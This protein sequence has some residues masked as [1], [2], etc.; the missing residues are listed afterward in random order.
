MPASNRD[1]YLSRLRRQ[2]R[3]LVSIADQVSR[4]PNIDPLVFF[5]QTLQTLLKALGSGSAGLHL[6]DDDN[7]RMHLIDQIGTQP[8]ASWKILQLNDANPVS[9]AMRLASP[10]RGD[11]AG[12]GGVLSVPIIGVQLPLGTLSVALPWLPDDELPDW[13]AFLL[14]AGYL[15]GIA[16]EHSGLINELLHNFEQ[17]MDLRRREAERLQS[18][19]NENKY[20][21]SA[22][23]DLYN[24]VITDPLTGLCNRRHIMELLDQ[25]IGRSERS[26]Q[27]FCLGMADLDHFKSINDRFGHQAGDKA[28]ALLAKWL[29][30]NTRQIDTV[31]RYGGEEF[32]LLLPNCSLDAGCVVAD[33]LRLMVEANSQMLELFAACGGFRMSVGVAQYQTGMN[34]QQLTRLAD[35]ALYQA[36]ANGRN[37]VVAAKLAF[38]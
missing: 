10:Q 18:L 14:G 11:I 9:Q 20:L 12:I 8:L 31:G 1:D 2:Q 27:P 38:A 22:N 32:M 19:E 6:F 35:E 33:K 21:Q 7:Q 36:K 24:L 30:E 28:L 13:E 17:I 29:L 3:A 23:M 4:Q 26:G 25:E 34:G 15:T 5:P 37:Q 16:L